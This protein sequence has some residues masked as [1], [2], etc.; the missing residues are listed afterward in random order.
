MHTYRLKLFLD[1]YSNGFGIADEEDGM[2]DEGDKGKRKLVCGT[3]K[4]KHK[5]KN[6]KT[7]GKFICRSMFIFSVAYIRYSK[8]FVSCTLCFTQFHCW[9]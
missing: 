6:L 2:I 8:Y 9:R 1:Q 3:T 5:A 7:A 4:E